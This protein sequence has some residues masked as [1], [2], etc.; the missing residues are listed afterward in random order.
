M[1]GLTYLINALGGRD[2]LTEED[3]ARILGL[4]QRKKSFPK[5]AQLV[6]E[7]TR[8]PE[9]CLITGGLAAREAFLAD[10]SRQISAIHVP[11]DFVDL[12]AF[13]LKLM[14]HSVVALTDCEAIFVPHSDLLRISEQAPHLTRLF[15]L[16]TVIDGA[17]QRAWIASIGRRSPMSHISHL[18]C[19]LYLRLQVAGLVV[20]D[21][22]DLPVTQYDLA[23]MM[24]LS[25]VHVNRVLKSL[26][27]TDYFTW[28]AGRVHIR[29]FDALAKLG[30][31]DPTYLNL[32]REPR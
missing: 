25:L 27:R 26:K 8:P 23:D 6:I 15:W 32:T 30:D 2:E 7:H 17:I 20:D 5:G 9:S 3:R 11:G 18:L 28:E 31:F 1:S 24:G 10:G 21:A 12:H 19:E 29:D 22:F 13:L 16:S 14:D 4:T